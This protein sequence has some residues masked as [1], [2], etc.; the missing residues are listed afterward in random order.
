[1]RGFD[2]PQT[3]L[4]SFVQVDDRVPAQHPLRTVRTAAAE[5]LNEL[6]P[7]IDD[8]YARGSRSAIAAEP[9][10]RAQLLWALYGIPS[11]MRLLEE[12][13]YN[14]LYRWFIGLGLEDPV[15][16]RSTFRSNK[17]RLIEAGL[18][19]EFLAR[20]LTRLPRRLVFH[21]FFAPNL[22]LVEDWGGQMDMDW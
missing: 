4:F 13:D 1:M 19:G 21:P 7:R 18:S 5:V 8:C 22:A 15:W 9:I 2:Q 17:E 11:E 14:L 16:A 6:Q 10:L 20:T 12:L 3:R